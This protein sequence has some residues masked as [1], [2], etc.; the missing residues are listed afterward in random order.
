MIAKVK[1]VKPTTAGRPTTAGTLLTS[2]MTATA[3]TLG[4]SWMSTAA[5]PPE[6]DSMGKSATIE[7]T[8]TFSR[9]A[10]SRIRNSQLEH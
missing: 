5:E 10:S 4:T 6:S 7:K 3:G 8:A 2:E 9:D 1:V